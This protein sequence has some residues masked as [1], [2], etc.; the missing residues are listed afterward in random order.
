MSFFDGPSIG[1]RVARYRKLNGWTMEELAARTRP[2]VAKLSKGVIANIETGRKLELSV[3]QL[4]ALSAALEVPPVALIMDIDD[5]TSDEI[6][7]VG[8]ANSRRFGI[9]GWLTGHWPAPDHEEA[10]PS[11]I[12]TERKMDALHEYTAAFRRVIDDRRIVNSEWDNYE[13]LLART[14]DPDFEKSSDYRE[15]LLEM[16]AARVAVTRIQENIDR[17]E[18]ALQRLLDLGIKVREEL[19]GTSADPAQ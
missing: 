11:R 3:S 2:E 5:L 15:V 4:L 16:A 7:H 18:A 17:Q 9:F 14:K 10:S 1:R 19:R 8:R 12:D 13:R 6:F